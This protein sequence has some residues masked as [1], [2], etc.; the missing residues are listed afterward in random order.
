MLIERH[1]GCGVK[2]EIRSS[3]SFLLGY[4]QPTLEVIR[5]REGSASNQELG[6]QASARMGLP[7]SNN[8][9][10]RSREG[11]SVRGCQQDGVGTELSE[12][13]GLAR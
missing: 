1:L 3:E 4:I 9:S 11:D 2:D 12:E 7:P 8:R 10:T 5:E 13:S 6:E